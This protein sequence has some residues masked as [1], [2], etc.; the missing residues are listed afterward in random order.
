MNGSFRLENVRLTLTNLSVP[1]H[2]DNALIDRWPIVF[3]NFIN[4]PWLLFV[5]NETPVKSFY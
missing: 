3:E 5:E 2:F 4:L 1:H